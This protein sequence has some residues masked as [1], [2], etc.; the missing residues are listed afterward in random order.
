MTETRRVIVTGAGRGLGRAMAEGL[1]EAGHRVLIV[2]RD[3]DVVEEAAAAHADL[4]PCVADLSTAEGLDA[5]IA[6]ADDK[7]DGFD[8]LVNN[9]GVSQDSIRAD[10]LARPIAFDEV[11][12]AQ[13]ELFFRV[14]AMAPVLLCNR[15][16]RRFRK[17]GWG[18]IVNVTTS[19][20]TMLRAGFAPYGTTKAAIEAHS[21]IMAAEFAGSGVTVNVLIPGGPADT[22]M[23]PEG[24][25]FDRSKL[26]RPRDMVPPL[27]WLIGEMD[28]PPNDLRLI[29]AS[30]D[31]ENP[32]RAA[33]IGWPPAESV[34]KWPE[35]SGR[36]GT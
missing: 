2:D 17:A 25:G 35:G 32:R 27:L 1:A 23:I 21:A 33:P 22:R 10:F 20:D 26:I 3:A 28:Y 24:A 5:V 18:R 30:F 12:D 29:A 8:V 19:L 13:Y 11:T 14:N 4:F 36:E 6:A 34:T 9:A 31:P 15:A 7:L 16:A